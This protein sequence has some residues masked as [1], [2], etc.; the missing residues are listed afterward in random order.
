MSVVHKY[1]NWYF[2]H[3]TESHYI[4]IIL[5]K[6]KGNESIYKQKS[7]V[8]FQKKIKEEMKEE[9]KTEK[10]KIKGKS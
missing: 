9:Y 8:C 4:Q 10:I 1:H 3:I 6:T 2:T 5:L 7:K